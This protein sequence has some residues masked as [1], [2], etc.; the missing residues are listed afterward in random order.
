MVKKI[1]GVLLLIVLGFVGFVATRPGTFHIE[2]STSIAAPAE[3]V[4]AQIA[5]FHA[6]PAWSPW[7]HLDPQMQRTFDGAPSGVGA[8]YSWTGNDKVGEG[9]M[10]ITDA[11][12]AQNLGIK[13]E[14]LKPWAST[15][16]ATFAL[17]P[18]ADGTQVTWKM[19]G[20][21][22]FMAKTMGV[23]MNMDKMIGADFEKGLAGLKST[24]EAEAAKPA[25][26]SDATSTAQTAVPE[27]S[28][29]GH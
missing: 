13:L 12:P 9:R 24:A 29:G 25:E 10:T 17:T 20:K 15:C 26:P 27:G 21:N 6:W 16:T 3:V 18:A 5:D 4:Y 22:D 23:F 2:R 1:L 19:D 14:F 28:A 7:E 11:Q 8:I